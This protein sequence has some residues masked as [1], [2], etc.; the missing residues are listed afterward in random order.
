M[1]CGLFHGLWNFLRY[2]VLFG[3]PAHGTS[4]YFASTDIA[5]TDMEGFL[6]MFATL[7]VVMPVIYF[8]YKDKFR[9][10]PEHKG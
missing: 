2:K 6:G 9:Q 7:I 10:L 5:W 8:W 4:G 1:A 3:N